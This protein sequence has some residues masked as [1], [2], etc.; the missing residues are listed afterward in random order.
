MK[1]YKVCELEVFAAVGELLVS[2]L[3]GRDDLAY[4]IFEALLPQFQDRYP[5]HKILTHIVLGMAKDETEEKIIARVEGRLYP[6]P[7][8][9]DN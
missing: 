3:H 8:L 1:D 5:Y 9:P 6:L 2:K 7:N 4:A